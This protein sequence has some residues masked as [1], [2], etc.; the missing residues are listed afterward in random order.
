M[1]STLKILWYYEIFSEDGRIRSSKSLGICTTWSNCDSFLSYQNC[2]LRR[3][4]VW[5]Y[6]LVGERCNVICSNFTFHPWNSEPRISSA[7]RR[8]F[9][10]RWKRQESKD[11]ISF[12]L[13][14]EKI[15]PDSDASLKLQDKSEWWPGQN[16]VS[17]QLWIYWWSHIIG[18][19]PWVSNALRDWQLWK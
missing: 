7:A 1:E 10:I 5:S 9:S 15:C 6:P 12:V 17:W 2:I 8:F 14:Q 19:F 11:F 18:P 16:Y 4:D 13:N 3:R